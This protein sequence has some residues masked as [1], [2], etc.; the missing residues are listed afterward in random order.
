MKQSSSKE[1]VLKGISASPGICIGK[2]YAVDREGVDVV[3]RY[4]IS[5]KK[6]K[7]EVKRGG[8]GG[9]GVEFEKGFLESKRGARGIGRRRESLR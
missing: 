7:N 9:D 4:D 8:Y 2:A 5:E 6:V 3:D 1:I